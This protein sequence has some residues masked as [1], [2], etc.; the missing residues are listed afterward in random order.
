MM[1][2][3]A[4]AIA[5]ISAKA[6]NPSEAPSGS[7][8]SP[9]STMATGTG[10]LLTRSAASWR[11]LAGYTLWS[12]KAQ[13]SWRRRPGSSSTISN[14][15]SVVDIWSCHDGRCRRLSFGDKGQEDAYGGTNPSF[16]EYFEVTARHADQL[17]GLKGPDAG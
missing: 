11:V 12:E 17:S 2:L 13:R 16:G 4:G 6:A 14:G 7:G 5:R 1:T 3:V 9:R 15:L 8:G 10:S